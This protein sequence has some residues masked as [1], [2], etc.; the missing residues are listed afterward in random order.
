MQKSVLISKDVPTL[1]KDLK[2]QQTMTE[3]ERLEN[4]Q[5]PS[6]DKMFLQLST[7]ASGRFKWRRRTSSCFSAELSKVE[8]G[9]DSK[10]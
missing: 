2:H 5:A 1:Q 10:N 6:E 4:F 7:V 9:M 8:F 3:V